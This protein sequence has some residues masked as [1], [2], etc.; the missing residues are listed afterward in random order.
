MS[1]Q[2]ILKQVHPDERRR[3]LEDNA[4][5]V[6]EDYYYVRRL[7]EEE[8]EAVA[9]KLGHAMVEIAKYNQQKADYLARLKE[10]MAPYNI[11]VKEATEV[12][13]T[14]TEE[15]TGLAFEFKDL[16]NGMV[17]TYSEEGDLLGSRRMRPEEGENQVSIFRMRRSGT[18]D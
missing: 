12:L 3:Y 17:E 4:D 7:T 2:T 16:E 14:K 9:V 18:D 11:L 5:K 6:L 15:V 10:E 13:R 8:L 1:Y